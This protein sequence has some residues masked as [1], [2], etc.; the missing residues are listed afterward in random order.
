MGRILVF[1]AGAG[2]GA[3]AVRLLTPEPP[4]SRPERFRAG[5]LAAGS[6]PGVDARETL[7]KTQ[8]LLREIR[9]LVLHVDIPDD[10]LEAKLKAKIARQSRHPER[11][12]VQVA[13]GKVVLEGSAT[14]QESR[15]LVESISLIRGVKSVEDRFEPAP[16]EARAESRT[17][18][19]NPAPRFQSSGLPQPAS[20]PPAIAILAAIGG[21]SLVSQGY[22][23]RGPSGAALVA[24]GAALIGAS[25]AGL[26]DGGR[27]RTP[28]Y[29]RDG[30]PARAPSPG[31]LG[32]RSKIVP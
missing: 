11:I 13:A 21:L 7:A 4:A 6:R 10:L 8:S 22:R 14:A 23:N 16:E 1:I 27:K 32:S 30:S 5:K 18:A 26:W 19:E 29:Y 24:A 15:D 25:A 3:V 17:P 31:T 2:F 20:Y 12:K 9:S 28:P